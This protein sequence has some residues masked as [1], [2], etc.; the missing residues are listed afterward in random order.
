MLILWGRASSSNVKK[1]LW[2]LDELGL[3]FEHRNVGGQFGGLD[4]ESFL[5]INPNGLIPVLQDNDLTLWESNT[6]VRYL[7][8]QYGQDTLWIEECGKRALSERWM[9]WTM[10]S[11]FE[12]FK[13][14]LFHLV[15][16]PENQR[17]PAIVTKAIETF[18]QHLAI[19]ENELS[20][21]HY[22]SSDHLSVGD[23]IAGVLVYYYY[24]FKIERCRTFPHIEKWYKRLQTHPAYCKNI[25]TPIT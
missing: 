23:I 22:L 6:I 20:K 24:E 13:D 15:R 14:M 21:Q 3:Q 8:A 4:Q 7:A 10:N 1:V 2:T 5:K 25:M 19:I 17:D 12:P 11:L 18:E 16:L 9:D